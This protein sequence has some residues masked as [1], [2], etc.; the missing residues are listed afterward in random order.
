MF[1]VVDGNRSA[2]KHGAYALAEDILYLLV[3]DG[4]GRLLN[5]DGDFFAVSAEGAAMLCEILHCNVEE[6]SRR[7]ADVYAVDVAQIRT[8]LRAFL[9][10]LE[11]KGLIV[12]PNRTKC[13][14]RCMRA[15][16]GIAI[17]AWLQL[18]AVLPMTLRFRAWLLLAS[19]YLSVRLFGF[20]SMIAV[21]QRSSPTRSAP[22]EE[23]R[24]R[25]AKDI[26][27]RVR[28]V[29]ARHPFHL[30]CKEQALCC[31]WL[32]RR[33]GLPVELVLGVDLFPFATHCWCQLGSVILSDDCKRCECFAP[34]IIFAGSVDGLTRR[35]LNG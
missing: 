16:T 20:G 7:I 22:S 24:D 18:T 8:D 28:G 17:M 32:T 23:H 2:S 9:R 13:F 27:D 10:E 25:I 5:L 12:R 29:A 21:W 31:W 1:T 33:H 6:A 4:T 34:V 26:A 35:T 30:A 15:I 3:G 11:I 19:A 14:A